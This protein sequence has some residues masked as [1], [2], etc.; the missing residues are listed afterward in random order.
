M[1]EQAIFKQED[2]VQ[3]YNNLISSSD[4]ESSSDDSSDDDDSDGIEP[5][6]GKAND[7][8]FNHDD[9]F[10]EGGRGQDQGGQAV[11]GDGV[12]GMV[13]EERQGRI[14][15]VQLLVP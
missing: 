4:D 8:I 15:Q 3:P 10:N 6:N 13:P 1:K 7:Y 12:V 5:E 2:F 11:E 14:R 9:L